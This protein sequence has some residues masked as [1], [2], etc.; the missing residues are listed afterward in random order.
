MNRSFLNLF[1]IN[2]IVV[3]CLVSL[4]A[5]SVVNGLKLADP[6]LEITLWADW[7]TLPILM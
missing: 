3:T 4:S 2:L 7:Q 6:E 1:L 5:Q